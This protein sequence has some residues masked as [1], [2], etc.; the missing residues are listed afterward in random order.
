MDT[1]DPHPLSSTSIRP[2]LPMNAVGDLLSAMWRWLWLPTLLDGASFLAAAL[3]ML[4]GA[5]LSSQS[6]RGYPH[7][8]MPLA[9]VTGRVTGVRRYHGFWERSAALG[10]YVTVDVEPTDGGAP[11]RLEDPELTGAQNRLRVLRTGQ[12]I[13]ARYDPQTNRVWELQSMGLTVIGPN[14]I[15][16]WRAEDQTAGRRRAWFL[17]GGS[18]LLALAWTWRRTRPDPTA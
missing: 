4:L 12:P 17:T 11:V 8:Y 14:E 3:F 7:R 9:E 5:A 6:G 1:S 13:T 15:A 10:P 16:R 2:V 18:V